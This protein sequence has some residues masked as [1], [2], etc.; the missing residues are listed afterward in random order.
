V[1]LI[2]EADADAAAARAALEIANACDA[3]LDERKIA[4]IALSGGRTPWQMIE[5]L[6]T[7]VLG[8]GD[9]HVAQVDERVVPPGDER[10]NITRLEEVLVREG[11]LS[12]NNLLDMPVCATDLAAAA[13]SYQA[14]LEAIGGTPLRFD[15]VQLGLGVDGHTASLVPG[16]PLLD[17]VED[18]VAVSAE[19]QGT[20]RM[21]L[22]LNALSRARQRVW[23]IT[24][25][26]KAP[27]LKD[28]IEG[29]AVIPANRVERR[30]T[31]VVADL[32]ACPPGLATVVN[33]S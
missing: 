19:Y 28:L 31:L 33:P 29:T 4:L 32:A 10:R 14:I 5:K 1:R 7:C 11:P 18:D 22:T 6:R 20:R 30:G 16:D 17:A 13:R 27:R 25:A 21:T 12:R 3:A 26:E 2:V 15:V 23:L 24:G 9:I 8:W